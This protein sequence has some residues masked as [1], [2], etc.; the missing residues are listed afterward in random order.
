[1]VDRG[2]LLSGDRLSVDARYD[3]ASY[4][5]RGSDRTAAHRTAPRAT[6]YRAAP[7]NYTQS[8]RV[9]P[10]ANETDTQFRAHRHQCRVVL[11]PDVASDHQLR[12]VKTQH[13]VRY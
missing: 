7:V 9:H 12:S 2:G 1:M 11:R 10:A 8:R 5:A 4:V 13:F 3:G 6:S